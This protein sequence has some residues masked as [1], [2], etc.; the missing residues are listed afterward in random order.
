[1]KVDRFCFNG[2]ICNIM[3]H[4]Q[5]VF[6]LCFNFYYD[7]IKKVTNHIP[8]QNVSNIFSHIFP[9]IFWLK[10]T[11]FWHLWVAIFQGWIWISN[12]L[13]QIV[14]Q[15]CNLKVESYALNTDTSHFLMT[16]PNLDHQNTDFFMRILFFYWTL[17]HW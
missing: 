13:Y 17:I 12:F 10:I 11:K 1:M 14:L 2:E 3:S 8:N 5:R 4:G 6:H 9:F 7:L 16:Y 15:C